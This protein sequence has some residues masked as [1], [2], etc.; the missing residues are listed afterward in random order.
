MKCLSSVSSRTRYEVHV[1]TSE[2]LPRTRPDISLSLRIRIRLCA[3]PRSSHSRCSAL[4][5]L[6]TRNAK[7]LPLGRTPSQ[8]QVRI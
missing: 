5:A 1:P 4:S 2:K 7:C 8:Q 6:F 3:A